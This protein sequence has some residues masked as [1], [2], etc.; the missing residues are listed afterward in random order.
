[1]SH[2]YFN[3]S[4]RNKLLLPLSCQTDSHPYSGIVNFNSDPFMWSKLSRCFFP[5]SSFYRLLNRFHS[6]EKEVKEFLHVTTKSKGW[7]TDYNTVHN[8]SS[9]LRVDELMVDYPRIYNNLISLERHAR[10]SLEEIFD[11]YTVNEWL[12]QRIYP[13]LKKLEQLEA[14]ALSLKAIKYWPVRPLK[15]VRSYD[16]QSNSPG[17]VKHV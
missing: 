4:L 6:T 17:S 10:E 15:S 3:Q 12:E 2:G 16:E 7:M 8:F 11:Q 1:M 5:G 13:Y 14:N 9:P